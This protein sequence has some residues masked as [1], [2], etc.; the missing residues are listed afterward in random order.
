LSSKIF[1]KVEGEKNPAT[2]PGKLANI[3]KT[4]EGRW[5]KPNARAAAASMAMPVEEQNT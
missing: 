1:R 2:R 3:A 5:T 4:D